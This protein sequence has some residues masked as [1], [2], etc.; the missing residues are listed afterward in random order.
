MA[1]GETKVYFDGS[2]YIAIPHTTRPSRKRY[3]MPEETVE[4]VDEN[5]ASANKPNQNNETNSTPSELEGVPFELEEIDFEEIEDIEDVFAESEPTPPT[6]SPRRATRKEI[7]E[8][9][10]KEALDMPRSKRKRHLIQKM[11]PY[12]QSDEKTEDYVR[13]N[14]ERKQRNLICR[15]IR[16]CRKANLQDFNY[17]CT[18]TYDSKLHSEDSFK[19]KLKTALRHFCSRRGWK[20]MGVWERSPEKK[21]LHFHG[22]FYIPEGTMPEM[23]IERN[24]YSFNTHKRQTINQNT[25]FLTRFGRND[26]EPIDDKTRMG[27]AM[28]YLMKYIEKSEERIVYSKGLPQYFI[29]DVLEED[30]VTVIGQEEKKL[31]LYDDFN[32]FDEGCYVGV[33]SPDVIKQMRKVN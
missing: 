23:C 5:N 20:Y 4:V 19:K 12:F 26:F 31:L 27:E 7:F 33:V 6:P 17:F 3:K 13:A 14:L 29:S 32:C 11:R 10:Y 18:F 22:I 16:M 1:Y 25:Y 30:V 2:H 21:R 28:A 8:E 24:D 15:R 9:G